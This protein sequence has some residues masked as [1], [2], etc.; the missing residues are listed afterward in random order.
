MVVTWR[1]GAE[2]S[3]GSVA[4]A[5][6]LQGETLKH[7]REAATRYYLGEVPPQPTTRLEELA[8]AIDRGTVG[9]AEA[10]DEL[11]RAE[12][13][14]LPAEADVDIDT[15]QGRIGT[16]LADAA[17]RAG[18][19]KE[20]A[21]AGGTVA[22]LRPDLSSAFAARLGIA[23]RS[24]PLTTGEIA[25]LMNNQRADG[26]A[27]EGRKKHAAHRSVAE[28]FGLEPKA[29]PSVTAIENVLAGRRADGVVPRVATGNGEPLAAKV[30]ESSL[31][32]FKAAIGV[33]ADR[34]ATADQIA[35]VAT[36]QIDVAGYLKQINATTPPVA[37]VDLTFSA[38]K[39]VSLSFALAPTE[40]E[41]AI[42]LSI[43]RDATADAMAYA[44]ESLG[45]ARRGAGGLGATE[46]AELAWIGFQHYTSRPAVDVVRRDAEGR[47][48]TDPREVPVATADPNLHQHVVALSSILTDG[49]HAGSLDLNRLKG[50]VKVIGAVFHAAIATRARRFGVDTA[51]GPSGE[52]RVTGVPDWVRTFFSR[53]TAQGEDAARRYAKD[54]GLDWDT[55]SGDERVELMQRGTAATRRDKMVDEGRSDFAVWREDA[56]AAG[57]RHRSVLRLDEVKPTLTNERRIE[58][59][60]AAAMPLLSEAFQKRAV[61]SGD[62]VREIAA[63]GLVAAGLGDRPA[64][65]IAA[66]TK[67]FR[68]RGVMIAG[69]WT[70]LVWGMEPGEGGRPRTVVTTGHTIEQ[71][72]ELVALVREA[73]ADR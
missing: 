34:D 12:L 17:T 21:A 54:H 11:I 73:A 47:E 44:E 70:R 3:S 33:P 10:L 55:L 57:Y 71:E 25:N 39:S 14:A 67:A 59:A 27:I 24:R 49:G 2:S 20:L 64:D 38:D 7:E 32:K 50:E 28:V 60:R 52:A 36:G 65:D 15:L 61:L 56:A 19:A 8:Q 29:L 4:Y 42:W 31:R 43:V 18:Y 63:R 62:D 37:F 16:E 30:V 51:L 66:V 48:F 58:L 13:A 46:R 68:E 26:G 53:R 23:D 41:R 35:R 40:V 5:T 72:R 6:Y 45:V 22:E 9:Y 69:E 1:V